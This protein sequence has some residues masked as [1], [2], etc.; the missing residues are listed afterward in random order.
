MREDFQ[1]KQITAAARN[2][3]QEYGSLLELVQKEL[4][5]E[6]DGELVDGK[7]AFDFARKTITKEARKQA[8]RDFVNRIKTHG[9]KQL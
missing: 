6:T 2:L 5:E 3:I 9:N 4:T 7:D 1:N 8:F